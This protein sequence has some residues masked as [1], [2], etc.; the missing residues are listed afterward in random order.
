MCNAKE[1][2][3]DSST[4]SPQSTPSKVPG[5]TSSAVQS[6]TT[7][8]PSNVMTSS[9][10]HTVSNYVTTVTRKETTDPIGS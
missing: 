4:V 2:L 8:L 9:A 5:A 1:L 6:I 7:T 10:D 3:P